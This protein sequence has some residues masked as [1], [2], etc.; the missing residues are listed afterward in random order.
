[1]SNTPAGWYP[2]EDGRQRY[3]DGEKWT[4]HFAPG[5]NQ[6]ASVGEAAA[7]NPTVAEPVGRPW[8]KKKRFIIPAGVVGLIFFGSAIGAASDNPKEPT[9]VAAAS[10]SSSPEVSAEPAV[11]EVTS[12]SSP[13]PTP[14]A[15]KKPSPKPAATKAKPTVTRAQE[16]ALRSAESY[17]DFKG[18]SKKGLIQQLSSEYGDGYKKA[19]ATW[20]VEHVDVNWKEQAVRAGEA[21]LDFKGFSRQ[22]LIEQLSSEYGDQFTVKEATYAADKLGL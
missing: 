20:A 5:S 11:E 18:F 17:L 3:W 4:E 21:Y 8:F 6:A 2:Q 1:M 22:G 14:T 15:T 12:S 13:T 9:Q 10:P 19:D 16:N 7:A